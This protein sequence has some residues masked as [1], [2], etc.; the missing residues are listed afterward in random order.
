MMEYEIGH[1]QLRQG[2]CAN[3]LQDHLFFLVDFLPL[4]YSEYPVAIETYLLSDCLE[5]IPLKIVW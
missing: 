1:Y 4:P 3:N 5:Y 2:I